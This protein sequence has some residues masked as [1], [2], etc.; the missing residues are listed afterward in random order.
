[1]N[2]STCFEPNLYLHKIQE[3]YIRHTDGCTVNSEAE[4][5]RVIQCLKAAIKRRVSEVIFGL[6]FDLLVLDIRMK[7]RSIDSLST[8]GL[9]FEWCPFP[10][11]FVSSEAHI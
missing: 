4:R 9:K 10:P 7:L 2:L 6:G 8:K 5:R 3:Y 11:L 1:M